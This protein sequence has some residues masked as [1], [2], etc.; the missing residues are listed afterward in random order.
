MYCDCKSGGMLVRVMM[1]FGHGSQVHVLGQGNV[2]RGG[3]VSEHDCGSYVFG[4]WISCA[5]GVG[6][7]LA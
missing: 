5:W 4:A 6:I 7:M 2:C 1:C 3:L